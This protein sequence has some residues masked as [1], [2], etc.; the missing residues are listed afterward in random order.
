MR[1]PSARRHSLT[2]SR[3]SAARRAFCRSSPRATKSARRSAPSPAP[4]HA[5]RAAGRRGRSAVTLGRRGTRARGR[6]AHQLP[7]PAARRTSS[8]S[9]P[10]RSASAQRIACGRSVIRAA[11]SAPR[12]RAS[13]SHA[14]VSSS[15]TPRSASTLLHRRSSGEQLPEQLAQ[16]LPRHVL[17]VG[18][19]VA[20]RHHGAE[21]RHLLLP[22][23]IEG[24]T[25]AL[26]P[27]SR[28]PMSETLTR[29]A[30]PAGAPD[31]R[32]FGPPKRG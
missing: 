12:T 21:P 15:S 19:V 11:C 28:W 27:A 14:R 30:A 25:S 20:L 29:S 1:V 16:E 17:D 8:R 18:A 7:P 10:R 6:L 31:A 26:R 4:R 13:A 5:R 32:P 23:D 9:S 2:A 3:P 24:P 22:Q